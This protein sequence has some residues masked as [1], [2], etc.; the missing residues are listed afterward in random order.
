MYGGVFLSVKNSVGNLMKIVL[1]LQI[2]F[3]RMAMFTVLTL[4]VPK[5]RMSFNILMVL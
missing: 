3:S 5:C 4:P 1:N 2:P